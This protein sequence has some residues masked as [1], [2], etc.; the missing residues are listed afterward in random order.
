MGALCAILVLYQYILLARVLLSWFPQLPPAAR[1]IAEIIFTLTEPV[2]KAVRPL[3]PPLRIGNIS[4]D[5][6]ILLLFVALSLL[7]GRVC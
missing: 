2:L 6:S 7:Q 5:V 3:L 4:L 1:P